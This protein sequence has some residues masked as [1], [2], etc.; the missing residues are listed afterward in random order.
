ME[1]PR[2]SGVSKAQ[3]LKEKYGTKGKSGTSRGGEGLKLK[4]IQWEGYGYFL[5]HHDVVNINL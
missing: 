3:F 1:I 4:K 5:K 2:G